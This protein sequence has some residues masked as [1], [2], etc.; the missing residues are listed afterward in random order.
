MGYA[1]FVIGAL[2]IIA[3]LQAP[4]AMV[5]CDRGATGELTVQSP[6]IVM[7]DSPGTA[8][9]YVRLDISNVPA[10]RQTFPGG[11]THG[12]PT[13]VT[14]NVTLF[15][16]PGEKTE[17]TVPLS[18]TAAGDRVFLTGHGTL[19][20]GK[21]APGIHR[22]HATNLAISVPSAGPCRLSDTE[23][24][25][26]FFMQ[27]AR[28]PA[29]GESYDA[30]VAVIQRLM[31]ALVI[32]AAG[33]FIYT[34]RPERLRRDRRPHT[35]GTPAPKHSTEPAGFETRPHLRFFRT[36]ASMAAGCLL[37]LGLVVSCVIDRHTTLE[38]LPGLPGQPSAPA[39][40]PP[41]PAGNA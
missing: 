17:I 25:G 37:T 29:G 28:A 18:G 39:P 6:S 35:A 31:M 10:T 23:P 14:G 33:V 11:E 40:P 20:P 12:I 5:T 41:R 16:Q 21:A 38:D 2:G 19:D 9:F 27:P 32:V 13:Q 4:S 22:L 26:E 15:L 24:V 34:N 3:T 7:A 1:P 36:F 8:R 30:L